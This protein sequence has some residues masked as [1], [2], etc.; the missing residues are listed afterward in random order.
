MTQAWITYREAAAILGIGPEAVKKRAAR[1][2]WPRRQG[3]DGLARIQMPEGHVLPSSSGR[4][5][6]MSR[7]AS[8]L[9]RD[10]D[11]RL[12]S[13]LE[14]M[15]SVL[16]A[17]LAHARVETESVR[18]DLAAEREAA[19]ETA[20]AYRRLTDELIELRKA[21]SSPPPPRRSA[22]RPRPAPEPASAATA[23]A[24]P[25]TGFI[26]REDFDVEG[27]MEAIRKRLEA[28][29]AERGH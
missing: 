10:G 16:Q 12:I 3:N 19:R 13:A 21:A 9:S 23:D 27:G 14:R 26:Q 22:P 24:P 29:L 20:A 18:A 8:R 15:I 17:D 5:A 11:D 6:D 1:G 28:R 4:P 25:S 7:D 2:R